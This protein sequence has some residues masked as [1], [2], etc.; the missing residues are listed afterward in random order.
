MTL[1]VPN[2]DVAAMSL[3]RVYFTFVHQ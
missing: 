3:L 1:L 2:D